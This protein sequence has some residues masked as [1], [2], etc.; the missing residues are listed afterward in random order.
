MKTKA[1][2]I[3][4][5]M[6]LRLEEIELPA[7]VAVNERAFKES[8]TRVLEKRFTD[9]QILQIQKEVTEKNTD[10]LYYVYEKNNP[11]AVYLWDDGQILLVDC[12]LSEDGQRVCRLLAR[13]EHIVTLCAS[14][15]I[16]KYI[17]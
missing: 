1:V 13:G 17:T 6:D 8:P 2:T 4:G 16:G 5:K 3:H 10:F 9:E 11:D 7:G 12:G 14:D 15:E